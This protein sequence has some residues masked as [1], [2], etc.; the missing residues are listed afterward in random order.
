M[1]TL[2]LS[3]IDSRLGEGAQANTTQAQAS[4]LMGGRPVVAN[5]TGTQLKLEDIDPRLA[6]SLPPS[7]SSQ[8]QPPPPSPLP[9]PNEQPLD[10]A[11]PQTEATLTGAAAGYGM[12]KL[13]ISQPKTLNFTRAQVQAA[14]KSKA[15]NRLQ[16]QIFNEVKQHGATVDKLTNN[17]S[18]AKS[19]HSNTKDAL[20]QAE[21]SLRS[22]GIEPNP[23]PKPTIEVE[24]E[25]PKLSAGAERHTN[26][27]SEIRTGNKVQR[28]LEGVKE[29][30][31]MGSL[32]GYSRNS[33]LIVPSELAEA[34]VLTPAQL[35]AH[36]TL[37]KAKAAHAESVTRLNKAQMA[38]EKHVAK[39]PIS[40]SLKSAAARVTE[41]AAEAADMLEGLKSSSPF[42]A[43][44]GTA[45]GK[46]PGLG[47]AGGALAGHDLYQ[48]YQDYE[49]QDYPEM[50]SHL[51]TGV[52][53]ALMSVP[54]PY[55]RVAGALVS[56]PGLAYQGYTY[57]HHPTEKKE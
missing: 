49:K 47:I 39:S 53:S 3:D 16:Q 26:K 34:P 46:I 20:T 21:E 48:A 30:E 18:Q 10:L 15:A 7:S 23:P 33:R 24:P 4:T 8:T 13:P 32:P 17:L 57:L 56:A 54:H 50:A 14:V 22:T 35:E 42:L 45:I 43:K 37:A 11:S 25:P 9:P 44:M 1:T 31:G 52:G 36:D 19:L 6:T 41:K 5:E 28:G 12:S 2:S 55:A 29:F 27:M 51:S 38:L 40:Q